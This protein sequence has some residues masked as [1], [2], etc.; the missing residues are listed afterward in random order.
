MKYD[1]KEKNKTW[2]E[3]KSTTGRKKAPEEKSTKGR[4]KV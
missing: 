2:I 1:R 4:K 3:E